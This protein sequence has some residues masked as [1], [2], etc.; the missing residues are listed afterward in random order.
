LWATGFLAAEIP[1]ATASRHTASS[2]LGPHQ[3]AHYTVTAARRFRIHPMFWAY[4]GTS[5]TRRTT[6]TQ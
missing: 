5:A 4:L 3:S 1:Q 2:F 6:R